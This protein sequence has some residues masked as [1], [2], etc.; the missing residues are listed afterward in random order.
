[1][2]PNWTKV[3]LFYVAT[4]VLTHGASLAYVVA[5]GSWGDS[6]SYA[7]ANVLMLC[8]AVVAIC[9]QYLVFRKPLAPSLGLR[10]RPNRWFV[11]A[12]LVPPL[13][14]LGAL[15][16]SLL[17]PRATFAADMSGLPPELQGFRALVVSL[18][19]P[20]L[21]G[22]LMIGLVLGL[23]LNAIGGLGEEIGWR[24][25]LFEELAPLG[26]WK[27]SIITGALWALWHVP[28]LFEGGY[29][30]R[31]HPIASALGTLA[32][33]LFL[34]P[35]LHVIRAR[36][37]S[38]VACGILHGTMSS[39]RLL[40]V[41]FVRDT[42]PWAHAAIPVALLAVA[43]LVVN[44]ATSRISARGASVVPTSV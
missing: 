20:P 19:M 32:F 17:L 43:L 24:G 10:F 39:T 6:S 31:E 36:S 13:V 18:G 25:F 3:G 8:P 11:V 16:F 44:A 4:F 7:M 21:L 28:L 35:I 9:L 42:G 37:G 26:F 22:M 2:R 41:A 30:D 38:V 1:M 40:S 27:C 23:S 14:M 33:A 34:A 15:G 29:G 5:G 12:W